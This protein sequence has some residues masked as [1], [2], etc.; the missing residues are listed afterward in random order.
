MRFA[1]IQFYLYLFSF[2]LGKEDIEV[3]KGTQSSALWS[4]LSIFPQPQDISD[5]GKTNVVI[6]NNYPVQNVLRVAI[7]C[8]HMF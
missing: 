4:K 3:L 5:F 6:T 2:E 1:N 8:M 7:K